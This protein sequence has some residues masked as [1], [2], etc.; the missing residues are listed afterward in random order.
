MW[1][2]S[3]PVKIIFSERLT[4]GIIPIIRDKN[5]IL[6]IC[7]QR[8]TKTEDY[9]N[10]TKGQ[11]R[12]TIF[13]DIENNPSFSSCQKAINH[14]KDLK[15]DTIIAI[16]G[17]SVLDTA[18][19]ARMAY[20]KSCY[21]IEKLFNNENIPVTK[22]LFIAIPTNHGTSSE[23]TM[24]AT[25]WDKKNNK[26]YSLSEFDNYPDYAIYDVNLINSLPVV[27]S[28]TSVLDALSHSFESLWNKNSNPIS[29]LFAIEAIKLII[30]N[31]SKL[32]NQ[33]TI[34]VRKNLLTASIYAGLAF[35]NTKTAA[36]HSI[37]YPLSLYFNI[38][39][40]IACSM[41]LFPLLKINQNTIQY[42]IDNLLNILR[43]NNIEELWRDVLNSVISKIPFTL[44]E[45]GV[46][47]SDINWLVDMS[48]TKDRMANNIVNLNKNDVYNILKD[49]Y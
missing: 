16:G 22:P 39:H 28:L 1:K 37:S 44:Q 7:S 38:P 13:M 20:Y 15:P 23:L 45:F 31:I 8:F 26:K 29:D 4:E 21:D 27:E 5:K 41:P 36:A 49:I 6:I 30:Q 24:W 47:K 19:A 32:N 33:T 40:G 17:G 9:N 42:K 10:L 18:K 43:L 3:N 12:Y 25:I 48:F 11:D 35:S 14:V 34:D 2:Y 46:K